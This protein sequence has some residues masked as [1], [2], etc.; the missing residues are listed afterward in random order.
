MKK[1]N[2]S[3]LSLPLLT[4]GS[5][6]LA[7]VTID[8]QSQPTIEQL[9]EVVKSATEDKNYS[10]ALRVA[11]NAIK[12]FPECATAYFYRATA[13]SNLCKIEEAK[14]DFE[15]AKK[16]YLAQLKNAKIS[17]QEKNEAQVKLEI[18]ERQLKRIQS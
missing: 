11:N 1:I 3:A 10:T 2:A 8:F 13:L 7:Q 9:I 15:Q 5:P 16:L 12:Q 6:V 4:F 14:L 17:P 18:I